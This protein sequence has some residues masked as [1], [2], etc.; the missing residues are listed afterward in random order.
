MVTE[1]ECKILE[2]QSYKC[3]FIISVF[4]LWFFFK[5]THPVTSLKAFPK[6]NVLWVEWTSPDESANRYILEWCVL[7]DKCALY[8][9]MATRDGTVHRTYLRGISC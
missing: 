6:D 1:N 2:L 5:A 7:S 9:R 8:P 3:S 4:I